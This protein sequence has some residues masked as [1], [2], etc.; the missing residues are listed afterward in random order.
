MRRHVIEE[1]LN[2]KQCYLKFESEKH[3]MEDKIV[4]MRGLENDKS[5]YQKWTFGITS[6]E[7]VPEEKIASA[8]QCLIDNG[9]EDDEAETVLQALCYILM[10]TEIFPEEEKNHE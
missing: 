4:L 9:I 7:T 10:D 8:K 6:Q 2:S 1:A 3:D 5:T